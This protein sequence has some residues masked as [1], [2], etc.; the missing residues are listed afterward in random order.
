MRQYNVLIFSFSGEESESSRRE[1]AQRLQEAAWIAAQ[2]SVLQKL[3]ER[4]LHKKEEEEAKERQIHRKALLLQELETRAR[5]SKERGIAL[6][7]RQLVLNV[8]HNL[9]IRTNT[10]SKFPSNI[11]HM[12]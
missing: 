11:L 2:G 6:F 9:A 7:N 4:D 1:A 10:R 5:R 12:E 8:D 3:R